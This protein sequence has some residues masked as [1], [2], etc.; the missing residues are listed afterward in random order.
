ME[1]IQF[2]ENKKALLG[3]D[4]EEYC[5]V[6]A[7]IMMVPGLGLGGDFVPSTAI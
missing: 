6:N 2:L 4:S 7:G 1:P 3:D 5:L